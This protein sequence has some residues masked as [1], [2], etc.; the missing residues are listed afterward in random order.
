MD[1]SICK[2]DARAALHASR[3]VAVL[4]AL[5]LGDLLVALPAFRALRAALPD[6]TIVL[7]GLPWARD[8]VARFRHYIDGFLEFPGFPGLPERNP[9]VADI[10]EFF[11][12]AQRE[13]FDLAIQMHGSGNLVNSLTALIGAQRMAGYCEP[14]GYCHDHELFMPWP[15][16]GHETERCLALM[17][18]LDFRADDTR[19]EFPLFARDREELR[20]LIDCHGL[21]ASNYVCLH[22]G[23]RYPSRRWGSEQFAAVGELLARR[24]L[25]VVLTG[26]TEEAALV[27]QVSRQLRAVHVDLAGQTTL[28][29]LAALIRQA[30]LLVSNDTGVSHVAAAVRTPSV[31]IVTGSDPERWA[32]LDKSRHRV[33]S[34]PI[35]CRPCSHR[36]CPIG[37]PCAKAVTPGEVFEQAQELLSR[38]WRDAPGG[39]NRVVQRPLVGR[40]S[41]AWSWQAP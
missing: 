18:F 25:Q 35:E 9:L 28:G 41:A 2:P 15:M 16:S 8:F 7:I 31:V 38:H 22:P 13:K 33:V 6:A 39:S 27:K 10:P 11:A 30:R 12:S 21:Q 17:R 23:A 1:R 4:R 32:P 19:V 29:G 37:H 40:Q 14:G 5:Q 20:L 34:S 24:G 36:D 3:H 26:S